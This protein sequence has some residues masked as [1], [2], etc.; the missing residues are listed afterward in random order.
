MTEGS[1]SPQDFDQTNDNKNTM[2]LL[3]LGD[4]NSIEW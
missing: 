2:M 3:Y 4:L 1:P